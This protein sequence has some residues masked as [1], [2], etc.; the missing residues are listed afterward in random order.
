LVPVVVAVLV[1]RP[2]FEEVVSGQLF[3]LKKQI[4][5]CLKE[6]A[7]VVVAAYATDPSTRETDTPTSRVDTN[8]FFMARKTELIEFGNHTQHP[9]INVEILLL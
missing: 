9:F 8:I 6:S 1:A 4:T 7:G 5:R 2:V 3:G